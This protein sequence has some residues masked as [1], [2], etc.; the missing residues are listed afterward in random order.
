[1]I[2]SGGDDG[3]V[4]LIKSDTGMEMNKIEITKVSL[5]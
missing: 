4:V 1:V 5:L 3:R 2:A